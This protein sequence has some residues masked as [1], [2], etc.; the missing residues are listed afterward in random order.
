MST[1]TGGQTGIHEAVEHGE[2]KLQEKARHLLYLHWYSQHWQTTANHARYGRVQTNYGLP[3]NEL[4][5]DHGICQN[6]ANPVSDDTRRAF[7]DNNNVLWHCLTCVT[8]TA[9]KDGAGARPDFE[10]RCDNT[11]ANGEGH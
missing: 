11:H 9:I 3:G 10:N 2:E 4:D 1:Q 6:C 7:G 5:A 8:A